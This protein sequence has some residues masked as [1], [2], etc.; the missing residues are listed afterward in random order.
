MEVHSV[1]I[2][3]T[4]LGETQGRHSDIHSGPP[5]DFQV[6]ELKAEFLYI[7]GHASIIAR[8]VSRCSQ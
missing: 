2:H 3:I 5:I 6:K 8:N 7:D 4:S 1:F